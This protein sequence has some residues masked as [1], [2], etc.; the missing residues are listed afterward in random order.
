MVDHSGPGLLGSSDRATGLGPSQSGCH[1]MIYLDHN[2]TT[3]VAPEVV[4]AMAPFLREE[5]GNP[6][7][8]YDLGQRGR[9]AVDRARQQ[10]AEL[11][12]AAPEEILFTSGGTESNNT[13]LKG[14]FYRSPRPFHMIT[15]RVEHPAIINPALF[16]MSHGADVTFVHA[17]GD[18]LVDPEDIRRAIRPETRLV[19]VMLANNE[20]GVIMPI[21]EISRITREHGIYLHTDAAQ[22]L[23]KIP[24]EVEQLGVDFLSV[25]GH[26]LY[27]P[28]GVG[29]L[30]IRR[31]LELEPLLHG[32]GQ[33]SG[34]RAGTENVMFVAGLGEACRLAAEK[35]HQEAPRLARL[36]DRLYLELKTAIPDLVLVGHPEK[37]LPNTLNICLPGFN[38]AEVLARTPEIR[39]STGSACH[40][41][42]V[43]VS[44]VLQA[45]GLPREVAQGALR[46]TLGRSNNE[47]QVDEAVR[48][49]GRAVQALAGHA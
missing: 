39:A 25:A 49:L 6:S 13:V 2:A 27:A 30:Y 36:R 37:R 35:L 9:Q 7:N 5:F 31:G 32:A 18:G 45:M 20:T 12:G 40:A 10:T 24:V 26:K 23:G 29:A 43:K 46:L 15:T 22:A 4:N 44:P 33:E 11:M 3:P 16:L 48:A 28:K 21:E 1:T 8:D 41:G 19:S 38:G 42:L 47:E 34:R 17:D 14:L